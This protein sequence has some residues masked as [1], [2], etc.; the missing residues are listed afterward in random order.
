MRKMKYKIEEYWGYYGRKYIYLI[1]HE[2]SS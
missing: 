2:A 1:I